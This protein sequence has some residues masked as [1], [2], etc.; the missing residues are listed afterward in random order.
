MFQFPTREVLWIRWKLTDWNILNNV[1]HWCRIFCH[2]ASMLLILRNI[3]ARFLK[4][5]PANRPFVSNSFFRPTTISKVAIIKA[6]SATIAFFS[7]ISSFLPP[8]SFFFAFPLSLLVWFWSL[9]GPRN[10]PFYAFSLKWRQISL[11][12]FPRNR[13][14]IIKSEKQI[15]QEEEMPFIHWNR[16][17]IEWFIEYLT[18]GKDWIAKVYNV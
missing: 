7:S 14:G 4:T 15:S 11:G 1:S 2:L 8:R 12:W 16:I 17:E 10:L 5:V 3:L 13:L 9:L 18:S 6:K